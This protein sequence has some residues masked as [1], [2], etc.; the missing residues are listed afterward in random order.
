MASTVAGSR[1]RVPSFSRLPLERAG[2]R[3]STR[4]SDRGDRV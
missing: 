4:E 2:V 1:V 3:A